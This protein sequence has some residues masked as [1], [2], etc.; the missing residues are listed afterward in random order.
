MDREEFRELRNVD[1]MTAEERD[2]ELSELQSRYG[3]FA[4]RKNEIHASMKPLTS[5]LARVNSEIARLGVRISQLKHGKK[6][7]PHVTDHAVVRYLE[8]NMGMD[9]DALRN[10]IM[11][12]PKAYREGNVVITV[13]GD[14]P[15]EQEI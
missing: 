12:H 11:V 8:R 14:K 13:M 10:S 15:E 2:S 5:E 7:V 4:R 9:I 1:D 3:K 6:D